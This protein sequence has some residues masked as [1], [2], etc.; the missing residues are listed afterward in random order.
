MRDRNRGGRAARAKAVSP[1][2]LALFTAGSPGAG[3]TTVIDGLVR[4]LPIVSRSPDD[5]LSELAQGADAGRRHE[6]L[7]QAFAVLEARQEEDIA[8]RRSLVVNTTAADLVFVTLLRDRLATDGYG[9]AMAFINASLT[10]ALARNAG[11]PFPVPE[12]TVAAKHAAVIANRDALEAL[13]A[14]SF[15]IVDN[16]RQRRLPPRLPALRACLRDLLQATT[17]PLS[18]A[19]REAHA[20]SEGAGRRVDL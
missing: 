17:G 15:W 1:A 13:F 14:P 3:K 7:P 12:A 11:R 2:P 18:A 19:E 5:I 20:G 6:L 9:C 16:D 8:R 4:G 10:T